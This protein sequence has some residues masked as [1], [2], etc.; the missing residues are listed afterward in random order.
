MT[1]QRTFSLS[2]NWQQIM[3]HVDH[4]TKARHLE[5]ET[6]GQQLDWS[7]CDPAMHIFIHAGFISI[8]RQH[9][10][11]APNQENSFHMNPAEP[12][13][14]YTARKQHMNVEVQRGMILSK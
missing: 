10:S 12:K 13:H 4:L 7:T 1:C 5:A 14:V 2:H 11:A 6:Q 8:I 9:T 3:S